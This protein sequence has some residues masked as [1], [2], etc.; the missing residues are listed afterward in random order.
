MKT[1]IFTFVFNRPDILKQQIESFRINL[2]DD[3]EFNVVYDTR[4]NKFLEEFKSICDETGVN[5]YHHLSQPGGTPSFYNSN[6]I[7][8]TYDTIISQESDDSLILVLD[9]DIFLIES[10]S[11]KDFMEDCD[12]AGLPQ[13][14]GHITYVWQGLLFFRKSSVI[15]EEFDFY[16]KQVEGQMLDSCGGTYALVRNS[17]LRY[18]KTDVKYPDEFN[19]IELSEVDEGYGFELHLD[20]KFLHFRNACGWHNHFNVSQNSQKKNVL[21]I[22]LDSLLK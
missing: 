5:F 2:K 11:I 17:N 7:Q 20:E 4:D 18:K 1:Q 10:F 16:P 19:G 22:M 12:F 14:R 3:Y 9:H 8:W 21:N 13:P 15:K 6:A